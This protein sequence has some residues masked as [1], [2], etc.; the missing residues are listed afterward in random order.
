MCL[1]MLFVY[2]LITYW[3]LIITRIGKRPSVLVIRSYILY[4]NKTLYTYDIISLDKVIQ[5]KMKSYICFL[6][7][8]AI[9]KIS[10]KNVELLSFIYSIQ[11]SYHFTRFCN[12]NK[13]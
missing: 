7:K 5:R 2:D 4:P 11:S 10:E 8:N 13:F 3:F 1:Y 6:Y 12:L 9:V